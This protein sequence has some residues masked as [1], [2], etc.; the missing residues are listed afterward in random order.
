MVTQS[1]VQL[2]LRGRRAK[3]TPTRHSSHEAMKQAVYSPRVA[4]APLQRL[5]NGRVIAVHKLG[6]VDPLLRAKLLHR[7]EHVL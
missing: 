7:L 3:E 2:N 5:E 1:E 4:P 6:T